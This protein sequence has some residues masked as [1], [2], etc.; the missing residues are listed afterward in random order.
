MELSV[1]EQLLDW[2]RNRYF[3]KYRGIVTA[4]DDS[5]KRGRVKVKVPSVYGS[6]LEVWAMP[7][8]PYAGAN[9]GVYM[10]PE[11]GA[12][13]WVEFEAGDTSFPIWT[14]GYWVDEELPKNQQNNQAEPS[15]RIIR[16]E[17]GLMISFNDDS[18][19][20][21]LSDKDG[22][23]MMTLEV[24]DGKIR[25]KGNMK[26]IVEAPQIEI[27]ENTTHPLVYG[28]DLL[29]YLTT[30]VTTFNS[31]IHPGLILPNGSVITTPTMMTAAPPSPGLLSTK[32][33]A[34]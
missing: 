20:I 4:N 18:E 9:V 26:I 6:E 28:D 29:Q 24:R 31:H 10:I 21:T 14:G 13:V 22:S 34:G 17:K 30:L 32:V 2:T 5:T 33:K 27:V 7:C 19:T 12:G 23:N 8:L 25:L 16:S 11:P 1:T 3:G 15:L